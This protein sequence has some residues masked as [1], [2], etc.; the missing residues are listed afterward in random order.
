VEIF[1]F[2][3]ASTPALEAHPASCPVGTVRNKSPGREA[4]EVKNLWRYTSTPQLAFRVPCF[5]KYR[6]RF[7]FYL[8]LGGFI[9]HGL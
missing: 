1:L 6:N 8:E 2:V 3:T 4:A 9:L 7:I 5:I